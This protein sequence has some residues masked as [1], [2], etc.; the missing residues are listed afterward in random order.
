MK[1]YKE[2]FYD[3]KKIKEED[4]RKLPQKYSSKNYST[5]VVSHKYF[6]YFQISCLK[7]SSKDTASGCL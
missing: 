2:Q 4:T 3:N 5:W 7:E 6:V 1:N